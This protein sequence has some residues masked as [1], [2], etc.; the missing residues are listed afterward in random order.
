VRRGS[1]PP[2]GSAWLEVSAA[3]RRGTLAKGNNG[4][5]V[6]RLVTIP[7]S[8]YCEKARWA[9]DRA[10]MLYREEPHVQ[11]I[12]RLAARRAGGGSTVP[13]LVT[14]QGA[15]GDSADI[16][17]WIDQRMEGEVRLYPA[18]PAARRE[19]LALCERFD[20]RLGPSGRR[21]M[22]VHMLGQRELTLQFNNQGVP[23]WEDRLLRRGWPFAVRFISRALGIRPGVE[24]EDESAAWRELDFAAGLLS[25]GRPYLCG[26]SFTAADLTFAALCAP[27]VVPVIYGVPLP[28]PEQMDPGTAALVQRAREHPA[29]SF[30]LRV[31]E[32]ERRRPLSPA[33]GAP[34]G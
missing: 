7:I 20:E 23:H 22:Y 15:I 33:G 26:E 34:A 1:S 29:G 17:A 28:Q 9:L 18:E 11:G 2:L 8:H 27:L 10:G 5:R 21:L 4:F 32:E 24:A 31:I 14:P 19:V 3:P 12:H 25:D 13:V 6:L 30:A 16:L